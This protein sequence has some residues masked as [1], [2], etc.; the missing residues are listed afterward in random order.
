MTSGQTVLPATQVPRSSGQYCL[1]L[2]SNADRFK[3]TQNQYTLTIRPRGALPITH[4]TA[5]IPATLT[6][7]SPLRPGDTDDDGDVDVTDL[8][9]LISHIRTTNSSLAPMFPADLRT[10]V[11]AIRSMRMP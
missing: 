2:A 3:T 7:S 9:A 11:T 10:L 5:T 6:L 4:T 8:L 1:T